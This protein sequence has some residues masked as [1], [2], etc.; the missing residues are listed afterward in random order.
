MLSL[1]LFFEL[2]G[3]AVYMRETLDIFQCLLPATPEDLQGGDGIALDS[4]LSTDED[5]IKTL[6]VKVPIVACI[7]QNIDNNGE[8]KYTIEGLKSDEE[9]GKFIVPYLSFAKSYFFT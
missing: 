7:V 6:Q 4:T 9:Q 2:N 5:G 8:Y 1:I 3:I